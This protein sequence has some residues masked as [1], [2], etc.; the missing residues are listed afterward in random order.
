MNRRNFTKLLPAMLLASTWSSTQLLA[1]KPKFSKPKFPKKLIKPRALKEGDTIGLVAPGSPITPEQLDIAKANLQSLG[2]EVRHTQSILLRKG[3]LAGN[4]RQR[5]ADINEFFKDESIQGIWC[6]RGGYGSARILPYLDFKM[7]KKN[8]KVF[9]GYSDVTALH[10]ALLRYAKLICFHG[11]VAGYEWSD[12]SK[13]HLSILMQKQKNVFI[14]PL[15]EAKEGNSIK[16][17]I[18]IK[19]GQ[20]TGILAGGN[21]SL[22]TSLLGTG[23][24]LDFKDK[25]VVLEDIGEQPYRIDRMLTQLLLQ[26]TL[27]NAAGIALGVMKNCE[28]KDMEGSLTLNQTLTDR[29]FQLDIPVVYGLSFGH[30]LNNATLPLGINAQLDVNNRTLELLESAVRN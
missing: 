20:A 8:P 17:S 3:Y 1:D 27:Q 24:E 25:I 30:V 10:I 15:I 2:F 7:I 13:E 16:D 19:S 29:L 5:A 18:T 9:V 11:P 23:Y 14:R 6:V 22:I 12:Y 21:L 28:A 26:G 4:D